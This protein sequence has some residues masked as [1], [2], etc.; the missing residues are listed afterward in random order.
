MSIK[1]AVNRESVDV[2]RI[3][4]DSAEKSAAHLEDLTSNLFQKIDFSNA[5]LGRYKDSIEEVVYRVSATQKQLSEYLLFLVPRMREVADAIERAIVPPQIQNTANGEFN[6]GS[7]ETLQKENTDEMP[8]YDEKLRPI[9]RFPR[10]LPETSFEFELDSNGLYTYDSPLEMDQYL[11]AAQ[12]TAYPDRFLGT[13]GLCSCANVLRLSGVDYTEADIIDFASNEPAQDFPFNRL[14]VVTPND[15]YSNG[16]TSPKGRQKI[17]EHFGISSGLLEVKMDKGQAS[18][19][20]IKQIA[21]LVSD[22]R[23]VIL[24][25][26]EDALYHDYGLKEDLHAVTVTSVS[27]DLEGKIVG[28]YICDSNIGTN[29]FSVNRI[30]NA[31]S[32][33]DANF[34]H[35]HIR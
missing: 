16:G 17:L 21:D 7:I 4:A 14:C 10:D 9:L 3:V 29:F 27:K 6:S 18:D 32:G 24:S 11:Y 19:E 20:S 22:G 12:G 5:Q 1:L 26:Y 31:L 15:K 33:R 34:T 28:F 25:V 2:L 35:S 8:E 13:C 30:K 23:G